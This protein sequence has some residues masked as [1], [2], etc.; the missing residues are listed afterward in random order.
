MAPWIFTHRNLPPKFLYI[1]MI[2][3]KLKWHLN[4][5]FFVDAQNVGHSLNIARLG[6]IEPLFF[7]CK[8]IVFFF[9]TR[10]E[11]II[12]CLKKKV[13]VEH[14]YKVSSR[15]ETKEQVEIYHCCTRCIWKLYQCDHC[16]AEFK[17]ENKTA[18]PITS[19]EQKKI[20]KKISKTNEIC[21]NM[22]DSLGSIMQSKK[23]WED[24]I[25][26]KKNI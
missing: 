20:T 21:H 17:N 24:C 1:E 19:T 16:W 6:I 8:A 3:L 25:S 5:S 18:L 14:H 13:R 15:I 23:F 10:I 22:R 12:H 7:S 11:N 9:Q 26:T 2:R 4:F